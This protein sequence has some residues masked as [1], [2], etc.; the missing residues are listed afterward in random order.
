[1]IVRFG[2]NGVAATRR[3][4]QRIAQRDR[5][6]RGVDF[7]Q[8]RE[9]RREHAVLK[10][11]T[12]S[13]ECVVEHAPCGANGRR[14]ASGNIPHDAE[15]RGEV[16]GV[17]RVRAPRHPRVARI[18]QTD[19]RGGKPHRL[20]AGMERV[21]CIVAVDERLGELVPEPRAQCQPATGSPLIL[22][23][24][25][26]QPAGPVLCLVGGGPAEL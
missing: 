12:L 22:R 24:A 23:I 11:I 9:R 25:R 6:R 8:R 10:K 5:G 14:R 19:R 4:A 26:V 16:V 13:G 15:S 3:A 1:M 2:G 20:H 21:Q 7:D 17:S 18:H